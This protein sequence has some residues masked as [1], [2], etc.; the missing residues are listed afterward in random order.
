MCRQAGERRVRKEL[1]RLKE[2][3]FLDFLKI[4]FFLVFLGLVWFWF[5][6]GTGFGYVYTR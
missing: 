2:F 3:L 6:T 4:A 5:G 1:G